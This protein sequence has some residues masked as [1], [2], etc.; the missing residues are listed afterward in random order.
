MRRLKEL[1]LITLIIII[2][3]KVMALEGTF[4]VECTPAQVMPG[5]EV[6]CSIK[7]TSTDVVNN[8]KAKFSVSDGLEVIE[9]SPATRWAGDDL[10]TSN[11][12]IAIYNNSSGDISGNFDIGTLKL[13]VSDTASDGT[14]NLNFVSIQY[15]DTLEDPVSI[16]NKQVPI[17]VKNEV[18][19]KGLKSLSVEGYNLGPSFSPEGYDYNLTI[20]SKTFKINAVPANVNDTVTIYNVEDKDKSTPLDPNNITFVANGGSGMMAIVIVVGSGG[21]GNEYRIII[22]KETEE[23]DNTLASLTVGGKTVSCDAD[24]MCYVSL[25][26]VSSY[27]VD[28][29]LSDPDNFEI[30]GSNGGLGDYYKNEANIII[31]VKPKDSSSG[32]EGRTYT[33]VVKQNSSGGNPGGGSSG[34]IPSNPQTG[35]ISIFIITLILIAS[36]IVSLN[37]YKKNMNYYS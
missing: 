1:I 3:C 25:D 6:S 17:T 34:D 20:N 12:Q 28:A 19:E 21:T 30:D 7:G 29:T 2:P 27:S 35:N 22:V 33:V 18:L 37:L 24:D 13:K 4:E 14:L 8:I 15:Y 10:S 36:L 32:Y 26:D 31:I 11:D 5:E 9:F 23:Y 16:G